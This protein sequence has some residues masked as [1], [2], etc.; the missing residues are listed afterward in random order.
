MKALEEQ[1]QKAKKR[2]EHRQKVSGSLDS[3]NKSDKKNIHS[4]QKQTVA[5]KKRPSY[6]KE[7]IRLMLRYGR[8][9]IEFIGS[10]CSEQ[11][12][13][14]EQLR[15]FYEDIIK[16]FKQEKEVTPEYY[17][18]KE[19]PYP[20]L[21]GEIV[22]EQY[23]VSDRHQ[24][25]TGVRYERDKN[26]FATAKGALKA[27]K[28]HHLE[29]LQQQFQQQ[30]KDAAEDERNDIVEKMKQASRHRTSLK[31]SSLDELFPGVKRNRKKRKREC[32]NIK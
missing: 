31:Q 14:D 27:L 13:E 19:H 29:R 28:I 18:Q 26:K 12:F 4:V 6:E 3:D 16:R 32:L 22:M 1:Q 17:A 2:A 20:Q 30:L 10:Y 9:M 8:D 5:S 11:Q 24:E 23:G 7:I 21:T 15:E 25:K